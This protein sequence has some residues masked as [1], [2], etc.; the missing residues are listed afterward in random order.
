MPRRRMDSR[1][2]QQGQRAIREEY[3]RLAPDYDQRWSF[4]VR[5]TLKATVERLDLSGCRLLLDISCGTG[6]L[7]ERLASQDR[8][9]TS[10]GLDLCRRMLGAAKAKFD[11]RFACVN[12]TAQ[13]IP[14]SDE[15]FDQVVCCNAF[16]YYRNPE[17]CLAEMK[18]VL[19]S[20]G[21][22]LITDWCDDYLACKICDF[23]LRIFN[24][25]HFRTY[26]ARRCEALLKAAGFSRVNVETFRINWLWGMMTA[27]AER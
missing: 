1:D 3:D 14:F 13:E 18:R 24:A 26:G 17:Q 19:K 2:T 11:S 10:V 21:H 4:Y 5:E 20:G 23:F 12:A 22:I 6:A 25:A 7:S 15:S 27:R 8:P 9:I 16:H